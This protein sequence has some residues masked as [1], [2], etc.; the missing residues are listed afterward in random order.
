MGVQVAV[1]E[2]MDQLIPG[3]DAQVSRSLARAFDKQRIDVRCG[4]RAE[5]SEFKKFDKVLLAVGRQGVVKNLWAENIGIKVERDAISV[6]RELRTG[7]RSVFAAGDCIG[8]YMLAHIACYEGEL[9]VGNMFEKPEKRDYRAVPASIFSTPEVGTIGVSE[10][11]AKKFGVSYEAKTVHYLGVGM[12]HV[13]G[14]TQ[15]FVKVIVD[16]TTGCVIGAH[17]IGLQ[18]PEL[19][20]IFSVIMKNEVL[21]SDVR[22]TIFAHP[23]VSEIIAEVAREF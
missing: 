7:A 2:A 8:G 20:N 19:V 6:D 23:S 3:L 12:A 18:A 17:A 1:W 9:A 15:G 22:K 11:E 14:D 10:E 16:R 21:I 13:L 5:A 4:A